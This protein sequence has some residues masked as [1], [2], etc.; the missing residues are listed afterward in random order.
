MHEGVYPGAV[1]LAA[2]SGEIVFLEAVGHRSLMLGPA[3]M[4]R[5]TIFDLASLTKPLATTLAIMKLV[6]DGI[7]DLDQPL[8]TLLPCHVPE[9]KRPISPRML[10]SHSS[11]FLDWQPI[12]LELDRYPLRERKGILRGELLRIPLTF[13][14]GQGTLYSDLGFMMLEWLIEE[15]TG[16]PMNR[17]LDRYFYSPLSLE[18]TFI[19]DTALPRQFKAEQFAATEDCPWRAKV[20]QGTVHDENA[21]VLGG[22]SGHAGLFGTAEEAY[23][24]AN[25]LMRHFHGS[26]DD[27]LRPK[28]VRAFFTRQMPLGDGTWALGW[29]TPSLENSSSGSYFSNNSVGHL[30]FTGTSIWMDLDRDIVV[31]FLTNRV[32]PTRNNQKI[33]VFRPRLHDAIMGELGIR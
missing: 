24:L 9:E 28:T 4:H 1:L 2:Q 26:Q 5:K 6:D 33:K 12:Y 3:P 32:H 10:L 14:P 13:D 8:D 11:G 22:Y 19:Y 21:H 30:G 20:I 15:T 16:G 7:M 27:Y 17:F 31:I 29:D 23:L 25:L 18:R